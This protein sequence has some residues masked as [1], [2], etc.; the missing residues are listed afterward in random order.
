MRVGSDGEPADAAQRAGHPPPVGP[1][2][3]L[4]C[5]LEAKEVIVGEGALRRR[6]IVVRNPDEAQR[7]QEKR[8]DIVSEAARRLEELRQLKG[9]PH[10]R[11]ACALRAHPAFGR[12]IKQSKTDALSLDRAKVKR[13]ARLDGK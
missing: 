8:A 4:A 9:E 12:Y 7:D 5:G 6:F 3:K 11:A 13:D 2:K 1:R 10:T